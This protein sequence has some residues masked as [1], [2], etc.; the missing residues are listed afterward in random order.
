L[1]LLGGES[2]GRREKLSQK[3]GRREKLA[4]KVGRR[5]IS[6]ILLSLPPPLRTLDLPQPDMRA[7]AG[8]KTAS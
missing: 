6:I 5:E 4:E 7:V 2:F 1:R 3:I 8:Q